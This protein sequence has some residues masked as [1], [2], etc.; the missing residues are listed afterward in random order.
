MPI[1]RL[2]PPIPLNTPKGF[3]YAHFLQDAG[4]EADLFWIVF[5]EDGQIWTWSNEEVRACTR[6]SLT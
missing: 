3:G 5:H 6:S 4:A 2:D 1:T